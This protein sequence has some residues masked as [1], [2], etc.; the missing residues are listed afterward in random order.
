MNKTTMTLAAALALGASA[1]AATPDE[2]FAAK[3]WAGVADYC[4][5]A[6]ITNRLTASNSQAIYDACIASSSKDAA[7]RG[8]WI[9]KLG[10][11]SVETAFRN[12]VAKKNYNA[13]NWLNVN[14]STNHAWTTELLTAFAGDQEAMEASPRFMKNI[15][16]SYGYAKERE[17]DA[18][19]FCTAAVER[20]DWITAAALFQW[21]PS[22]RGWQFEESEALKAW[23]DANAAAVMAGIAAKSACGD[24]YSVCLFNISKR[25]LA[26][27]D[28]AN[29]EAMKYFYATAF[30]DGCL[31]EYSGSYV[32]WALGRA[33][34]E[35]FF[36]N[37]TDPVKIFN[38][39]RR[40]YSYSTSKYKE[41]ILANWTK[42][43]TGKTVAFKA[44]KVLDDGDKVLDALLIS[45]DNLTAEDINYV[46]SKIVGFDSDYRTA[47]VVKILKNINA[48]YTLKLYDDRDTWEPILSKVRA[49]IDTRL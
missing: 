14:T 35:A 31:P 32:D 17:A 9:A 46:I 19:A 1:F 7:A 20:H 44:A 16:V 34:H 40:G 26:A 25:D 37:A 6:Q 18:I 33:S 22:A 43:S 45:T 23:R 8:C 2:L 28:S 5:I 47:D 15:I 48:K 13:A 36:K 11:G 42:I 38:E 4:T 21:W 49:L 12:A 41:V 27:G 3:D 39:C 30:G 24:L 29:T 10:Y